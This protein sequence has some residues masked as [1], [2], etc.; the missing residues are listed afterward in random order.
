MTDFES[1]TDRPSCQFDKA[2]AVTER[3]TAL[4]IAAIRAECSSTVIS[5]DDCER[6]GAEIPIARQIAVPGVQK[7][8]PC[9]HRAW[10]AA[11]GVRRG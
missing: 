9:T 4:A 6:C 1:I 10:L 11:K 5:A 7:C 2:S 8:A 3:D